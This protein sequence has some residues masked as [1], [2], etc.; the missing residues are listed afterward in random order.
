MLFCFFEVKES[1]VEGRE[2]NLERKEAP[3][4]CVLR[5]RDAAVAGVVVYVLIE[6][7]R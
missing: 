3:V 6:R 2:E 7:V 1:T 5:E 4:V